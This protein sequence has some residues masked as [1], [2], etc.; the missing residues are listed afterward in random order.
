[1]SS[2]L[3]GPAMTA[4]E[5]GREQ[6][7][8]ASAIAVSRTT[9]TNRRMGTPQGEGSAHDTAALPSVVP[10][11]VACDENATRAVTPP[12]QPVDVGSPAGMVKQPALAA[13]E[14]PTALN[15]RTEKQ[16]L[17]SSGTSVQS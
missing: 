14:V 1:M 15:A 8:S 12:V 6:P 11:I 5:G 7:V 13:L 16:S 2:T 9:G 10:P 3:G 17:V 4:I